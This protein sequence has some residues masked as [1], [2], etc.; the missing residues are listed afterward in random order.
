MGE[1][2]GR[3]RGEGKGREGMEGKGGER[4][5]WERRTQSFYIEKGNPAYNPSTLGGPSGNHLRSGVQDPSGQY[6][7]TLYLLKNNN[8]K[9]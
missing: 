4:R 3:K 7:E 1:G 8:N 9:N 6:G 2:K 5:E